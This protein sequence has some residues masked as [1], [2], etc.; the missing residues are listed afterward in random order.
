M[1]A[2]G[3]G[4]V[5]LTATGATADLVFNGATSSGSGNI[6]G[7]A[8]RDITLNTGG[9]L[10]T[11]GNVT[12]NSAQTAAVGTIT[13]AGTGKILTAA[14]LTTNSKG[15]Q[16]L[17]NANTAASVNATNITSGNVALTNTV[18]T[19]TITGVSQ[20]GGGNVTVGNTG[21]L[22]VG[23]AVSAGGAGNVNLTATGLETIGA[24]VTAGGS[25]VANLAGFGI[26]NNNIVT[27]AG[28]VNVAAGT[29]TITN[30]GTLTNTGNAAA[31]TLTA[32]NM[33]LA[34]G[35][36]TGGSGVVT[37]TSTSAAQPITIGAGTTGLGLSI[38][39]INTISTTGTLQIGTA[40]HTADITVDGTAVFNPLTAGAGTVLLKN[41]GDIVVNAL[42]D[43]PT[44]IMDTPNPIRGTGIIGGGGTLTIARSGGIYGTVP[45]T[46]LITRVANLDAQNLIS[47]DVWIQNTRT[48][49]L[50]LINNFKNTAPGG[51]LWLEVPN[52]SINTGTVNVQTAGG[53]IV[54]SASDNGV[55]GGANIIIGTGG[56]TSNGGMVAL[57]AADNIN[58]NG[59]ISST[60]GNIEIIAGAR[61]NSGGGSTWVPGLLNGT[62]MLPATEAASDGTGLITLN[63][64]VNAGAGGDVVLISATVN[65]TG[66]VPQTE[67]IQTATGVITG[68][69]LT[70]VALRGT[71]GPSNG[72]GGISLN[73]ANT[74]TLNSATNVNLFACPEGGCPAGVNPFATAPMINN[75][76]PLN[77]PLVN[78]ADGPIF[79]TSASTNIS[80]VGTV[81]DF[82]FYNNGGFT[83]TGSTMF[84]RKLTFETNG[85]IDINLAS[86]ITNATIQTGG[87]L[88]FVAGNSINY[89]PSALGNTFGAPGNSLNR[90]VQFVAG[91]SIDI[92]N[93][94]YI[95]PTGSVTID[96]FQN[97]HFVSPPSPPLGPPCYV[98]VACIPANYNNPGAFNILQNGA[99]LV[100]FRGNHE[101]GVGGSLTVNANNLSV[102]G[103][104]SDVNSQVLG[105]R[106]NVTGIA[107]FNVAG[108]ILVQASTQSPIPGGPLV[109]DSAAIIQGG[110][111]N[112]GSAGARTNS[113]TL[114]GGTTTVTAGTSQV[115]NADAQINATGAALNVFLGAGGLTLTGGTA[116]V[117]NLATNAG[118]AS[119]I[120][121]LQGGALT[122][123]VTGNVMVAAGAATAQGGLAATSVDVGADASANINA[124]GA[125]GATIGRTL[126]VLGGNAVAAPTGATSAHA[127]ASALVKGSTLNV[128]VNN[129]GLAVNGL[130]LTGGTASAT[131]SPGTGSCGGAGGVCA[132]A[133]AVFSSSADKKISVAMGNFA[134]TGGSNANADGVSA[135]ATAFAGTNGG[136]VVTLATSLT[137]IAGGQVQLTGGNEYV[138]N[139]GRSVA[140]AVLQSTGG[141]EITGL[142]V[143]TGSAQ[144]N[145][146]QNFASTGTII[147]LTGLAPPIRTFSGFSR[148]V[149]V[150][151]PAFG[152]YTASNGIAFVLSGAPPSNLD[153]LQSALLSSLF[154]IK[155]AAA[156]QTTS[157]SSAAKPNYC[158]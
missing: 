158:K 4:N 20:T 75:I 137:V 116:T 1:S 92:N 120:A 154:L 109:S 40:A 140:S 61:G 113:L 70:A 94:M 27:A 147:T 83:L 37:L 111:I 62:L 46:P 58:V 76:G 134:I 44:I 148:P 79:Y 54:L 19:L 10:T 155:P 16:T 142:A 86:Q 42:I 145:L 135:L 14:L 115:R 8:G 12:L 29:G 51:K 21:N 121:N 33:N 146:Y 36:I 32:D 124:G 82:I 114:T 101:V 66:A 151:P 126:S 69:N 157:S 150:A 104:N 6:T 48:G 73:A 122:L 81:N 59:T 107:T 144:S 78:Y 106:L 102:L 125:L 85:T 133:N 67:I 7:N 24:A 25:G 56:I 99:G 131:A 110:T 63:A 49:T 5:N 149:P 93:A 128:T 90:D 136:N 2:G 11:T 30:T 47:G 38:G 18:G 23:G 123:D 117:T 45:G 57:H 132:T 22:T 118:Q 39:E 88:R 152:A 98:N 28:G 72:G 108:N 17:N 43:T 53:Q 9:D 68:N 80:G 119:A 26:T 60:N 87:F 34:G 3:A 91:N 65:N 41:G 15:G 52:G 129:T 141:I 71:G 97:I 105:E 35:T 127:L 31:I 77:P 143:L 103:G 13:E 156:P 130:T 55:P 153:P 138:Q 100:Q 84:G 89:N 95:G 96:A 50:N 139:G 64:P 74:P 112:I